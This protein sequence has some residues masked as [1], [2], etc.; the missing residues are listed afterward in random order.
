MADGIVWARS[1]ANRPPTAIDAVTG[2]MVVHFATDAAPTFDGGRGYFLS[3]GVL[4]ARDPRTQAAA[5]ELH[6]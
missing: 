1:I 6:R 2:A 4:E 5:L 3:H